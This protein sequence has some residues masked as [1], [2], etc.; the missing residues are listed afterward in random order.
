MKYTLS[1]NTSS[2]QTLLKICFVSTCNHYISIGQQF[3]YMNNLAIYYFIRQILL[4]QPFGIVFCGNSQHIPIFVVRS[5]Y[6]KT[7]HIFKTQILSHILRIR[8]DITS[9]LQISVI[10]FSPQDDATDKKK[11]ISD[12][13]LTFRAISAVLYASTRTIHFRIEFLCAVVF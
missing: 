8:C 2:F 7:L 9:Q 10:R 12:H 3:I 11:H 1:L 5:N 13:T 4:N 6:K